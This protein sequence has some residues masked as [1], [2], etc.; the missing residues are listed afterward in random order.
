MHCIAQEIDP[1]SYNNFKWSII[2]KNI[3]SL[4][5]IPETN[6]IL[7]ISYTSIKKKP[8]TIQQVK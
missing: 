7:Y 5:Y 1:I 6:I 2:Y 3:E 4:C 8:F